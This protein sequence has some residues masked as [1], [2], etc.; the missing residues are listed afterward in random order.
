MSHPHLEHH[1]AFVRTVELGSIT[2]AAKALGL[3]R[4]TLSRQIAAL[5]EALGLA[6]LHRTTRSVTPTPA[7]QRLY[8]EAAPHVDALA[9]VER[10]LREER[11][12]VSGRLRVSAPPVLGPPIA[13]LLIG[14]QAAHPALEVELITDIRHA[15]L[16][17]E[18]VEVAVRAG[19]VG[20]PDLVQRRLGRSWV[21]A[22]AS[23]GYLE[24]A[25][26]PEAL[27]DL[28]RHRLLRG[29]A[30]DGRPQRW[31]PLLD[32]GRVAVG[33]GFACNDQRALLD[34]ALAGG[35][36]ALLSAVTASEPLGDGRLV[37]VLPLVLGTRLDVHAVFA[38]RTLLP[39]RVRAFIDALVAWGAAFDVGG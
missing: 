36:I 6:L 12:T 28:S 14:L 8:A 5:E 2:A 9:G 13:G 4:P 25:G 20:D 1:L 11:D 15:D 29:F 30:A 17:A 7:G 21:S 22:V 10:R 24:S 31:W 19:R 39:A 34:G 37:A 32:G 33:G 38:Q 26:M 3:A 35:G 16:R 18:G 27:D 23:P